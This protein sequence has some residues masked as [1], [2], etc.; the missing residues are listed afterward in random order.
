MQRRIDGGIVT[1][2]VRDGVLRARG[3]PYGRA[4]RFDAAEQPAGWSAELDATRPGPACPQRASRL[5]FV[6]GPVLGDLV[7][8][9]D[10]LVV[11]VTA[12]VDADGLPVMV[13]L[14]GGAYVAGGG[15]SAKYDAG[16]LAREGD[17]VV[18][19]VTYRL[20]IFGYVAPP[21][22]D[23]DGNLGLRD[24]ILALTWVRDNVAS[25]GGDPANVTVFGQSAG[26]DAV[27]ALMLCEEADGLFHRA[28]A[29]SA[30]LGLGTQNVAAGAERVAVVAAMQEAMAESLAGVAPRDATRAQLLT[31][32][33]AAVEAALVFGV[34]GGGLAF[35]PLLGRAPLC[36]PD[37]VPDRLAA[38]AT[39]VELLIG[40]TRDDGAPFVAMDSRIQTLGVIKAAERLAIRAIAP[41]VT[42]RIFGALLDPFVETWRAAGGRVTKYRFDWA[43]ASAPL[44]ACHCIELPLLFEAGDVWSDAPM[45][46]GDGIDA[47]LAVRMRGL[48]A[49]FA[50]RGTGDLAASMIVN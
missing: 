36:A 47:D 32:E 10:C 24:Q 43:P 25:F 9:E 34:L 4:A 44:G 37:E 17:V 41:S 28:I 46:G 16:A 22:A 8:S 31:A 15:E 38:A 21:G 2:Q 48:W 39:R 42:Q 5:N 11:S 30:P 19:N 35:A 26:A 50:H 13:W 45:L 20:G 1:V 40:H 33:G 7:F 6:T 49:G 18:V 27:L 23:G 3:L 14:H 29:Q 12:P